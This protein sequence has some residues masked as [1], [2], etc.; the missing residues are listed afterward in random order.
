MDFPS[1]LLTR[2]RDSAFDVYTVN[3]QGLPTI[4]IFEERDDAERYV[5]M[6]EQDSDYVVGETIQLEITEVDLGDAV[7]IFNEKKQNYI[8][9]R[10][11]DLFIPPKANQ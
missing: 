3:Y 1:Y 6:L 2:K 9:I 10:E 8:L 11:D 5:I 4:L 7:D